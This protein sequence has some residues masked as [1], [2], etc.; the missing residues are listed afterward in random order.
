MKFE[1]EID[2][3]GN[4]TGLGNPDFLVMDLDINLRGQEASEVNLTSMFPNISSSY[5]DSTHKIKSAKILI[6]ID[7]DPICSFRFDNIPV[8]SSNS[9]KS[10]PMRIRKKNT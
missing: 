3:D 6:E 8:T 9:I 5:N 10:K 1:I 7:D 4:V 2:E